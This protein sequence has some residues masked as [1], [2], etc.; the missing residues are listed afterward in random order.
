MNYP[1]ILSKAFSKSMSTMDL[2]NAIRLSLL[3]D[4]FAY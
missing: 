1:E 3:S 2:V 4:G